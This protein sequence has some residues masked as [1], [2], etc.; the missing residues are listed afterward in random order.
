MLAQVHS[1]SAKRGGLVADVSSELIFLKNK[2]TKVGPTG[3]FFEQKHCN[4]LENMGDN[5]KPSF[6][7]R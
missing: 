5:I 7:V 6:R 1:F 4:I 3:D 2:Q